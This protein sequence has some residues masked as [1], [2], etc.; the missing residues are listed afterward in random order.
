MDIQIKTVRE[1]EDGSADAELF[2]DKD[3]M[4]LLIGEGFLSIIKEWIEQNKPNGN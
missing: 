4:A 1:N 3:A 2:L